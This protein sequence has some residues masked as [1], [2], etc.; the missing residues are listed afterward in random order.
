MVRAKSIPRVGFS[1]FQFF[2]LFFTWEER[3][4]EMMLTPNRS[5]GLAKLDLNMASDP[6]R[7]E[8]GLS[9]CVMV[10]QGMDTTEAHGA[11]RVGAED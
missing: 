11:K 1:S 4:L 9:A 6:T 8:W 2:F 7:G 3:S 10:G 5:K